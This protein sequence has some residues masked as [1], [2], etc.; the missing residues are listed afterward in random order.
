VAAP[1]V[2]APA[3]GGRSAPNE[4]GVHEVARL[5]LEG[6][7]VLAPVRQAYRLYGALNAARDNLVLVFHALTGSPEAAG[8]GGWWR[9]VVGP[10]CAVDTDRYA[11]LVPN[12]LGSCYGTTGPASPGAPDPFPPVTPRDMAR[13]AGLLVDALGVASVALVAGGSLGGMV[14]QEWALL[15]P[16]R[17]RAAAVLAAP[18]AHTALAIG[19][20]HLQREAVRLGRRAGDAAGGLALARMVGMLS[21]RTEAEFEARFGREPAPGDAG[22]TDAT[23]DDPSGGTPGGT[24]ARFAVQR[25]LDR[26]GEKLVRRFDPASYACLLDAMDAHDVGRGRGGRAAALRALGRAVDRLVAVGVPGDLLYGADV[27]RA[28]AEAAGAEYR[29]LRSAHGHDAFL[30]ETGQV[31]AALAAALGGAAAQG[32]SGA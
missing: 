20:N 15:H 24:P 17:A 7:R 16:G 25:Y 13:L 21:F 30:L 23:E 27:V 1:P 14:A 10:G 5:A 29:E 4:A 19:W 8:E 6:G 18:A 9:G 32:A 3:P 12:L 28:W 11:V 22:S 31:G 2:R 26:H